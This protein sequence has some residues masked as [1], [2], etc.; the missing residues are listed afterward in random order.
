M[1][2]NV[3]ASRGLDMA[4]TMS[5]GR[6]GKLWSLQRMLNERMRLAISSSAAGMTM[7]LELEASLRNS[8]AA[9][10]EV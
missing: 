6:S 3:L 4:P 1:G 10:G 8:K 5:D 9:E 2:T 7:R